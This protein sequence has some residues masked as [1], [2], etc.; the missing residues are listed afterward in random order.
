MNRTMAEAKTHYRASLG[1]GVKMVTE[2]TLKQNFPNPTGAAITSFVIYANESTITVDASNESFSLVGE[3]SYAGIDNSFTYGI[4]SFVNTVVTKNLTETRKF[5]NTS[6]AFGGLYLVTKD[7]NML[8]RM[9][10]DGTTVTAVRIM[11]FGNMNENRL[12]WFNG[13]ILTGTELVWV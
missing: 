2:T 4:N 10:S 11:G 9:V 8:Y 6:G 12:P 5:N 1:H 7:T 13:S 3:G